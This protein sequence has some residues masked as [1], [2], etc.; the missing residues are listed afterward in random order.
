[1]S[2]LSADP[3]KYP[4]RGENALYVE[5]VEI[6]QAQAEAASLAYSALTGSGAEIDPEYLIECIT[7]MDDRNHMFSF[8]LDEDDA[9]CIEAIREAHEDG[10]A[11]LKAVR[12]AK[13]KER[14]RELQARQAARQAELNAEHKAQHLAQNVK[15]GE[16]A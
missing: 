6:A 2:H 1:M 15:A 14:A 11:P 13:R 7:D 10:F 9:T 16:V 5:A 4:H 8:A 3:F 12:K